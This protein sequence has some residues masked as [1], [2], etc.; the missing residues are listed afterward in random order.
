MRACTS[1]RHERMEEVMGGQG[2]A[3]RDTAAWAVMP[4]GL[5]PRAGIMMFVGGA[6][7]G[8]PG[9]GYGPRSWG[10]HMGCGAAWP[11]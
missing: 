2:S 11:F 9:G 3:A 7:W 6:G 4:E 8:L 5:R 10:Y 1:G